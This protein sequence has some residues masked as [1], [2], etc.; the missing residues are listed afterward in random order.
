MYVLLLGVTVRSVECV[1]LSNMCKTIKSNLK[2]S[3]FVLFHLYYPLF[4]TD[5]YRKVLL[6]CGDL[7]VLVKQIKYSKGILK[8]FKASVFI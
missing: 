2:L 8:Y 7:Y 5:F 6:F 4:V 1:L 3:W